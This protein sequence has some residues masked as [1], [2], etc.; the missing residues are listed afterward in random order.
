MIS[1][2]LCYVLG[3]DQEGFNAQ[4]RSSQDG[5]YTQQLHGAAEKQPIASPQVPGTQSCWFHHQN[6]D[7]G[8]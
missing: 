7:V 4:P 2:P 1:D 5:H 6:D 3:D 8:E